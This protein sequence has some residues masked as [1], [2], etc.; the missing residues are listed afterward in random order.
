MKLTEME[1]HLLLSC[2]PDTGAAVYWA[3]VE[4]FGELGA[5]LATAPSRLA[6]F[7]KPA[8]IALL[9]EIR[10]GGEG[11]PLMQR[12]R[13]D[14]EWLT[15]HGVNLVCVTDARYPVLLKEIA[16]APP[17]LYVLGN[18][19]ALSMPQVAIVG[20][21]K[22]TRGGLEHAERFAA[23][24]A[25]GGLTVTSGLALGVDIAAHLGALAAGGPT[26]AVLA[27]GIDIVYPHRHLRAAA[28]IIAQ[29]GALVTEFSLRTPPHPAHFP[30]RNRIISGLSFGVLV[31]EAAVKSGSL[32]TARF[33]LAQNREVFAIPG[34][35]HNPL[36]RGCH[37]LLRDGAKL[38]ETAQDIL[39]EVPGFLSLKW[40][41]SLPRQVAA[42]EHLPGDMDCGTPE[43]E[44]LAQLDY[45][46]VS[47][48]SL[49]ERTGRAAGEVMAALLTLE[50]KGL[51]AS[52]GGGFVRH[53]VCDV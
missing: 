2:L 41:E 6:G 44:L 28:D 15:T 21:R 32:I 40:Q 16:R 31:V 48:E 12:V 26:I 5:A 19:D 24:L 38:V 47:L 36:S 23:E 3:L 25:R 1:Q 34:S 39:D 35:I 27:T 14:L 50:L 4:Q 30:Q 45:D 43:A 29:G 9:E 7:L 10:R 20:S 42:V 17:L 37:A 18:V 53:Q 13:Q 33:A 51:V 8:A 46:P 52:Q 11:H 49:V 22:P